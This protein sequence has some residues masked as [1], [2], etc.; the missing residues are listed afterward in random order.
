MSGFATASCLAE[1]VAA[2]DEEQ[3]S[4]AQ[5]SSVFK[6]QQTVFLALAC[7]SNSSACIIHKYQFITEDS[8]ITVYA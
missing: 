8:G 1:S 3:C 5:T 4:S 2:L 6:R 7:I